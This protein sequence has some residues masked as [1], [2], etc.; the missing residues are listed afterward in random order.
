MYGLTGFR[1]GSIGVPCGPHARGPVPRASRAKG[2]RGRGHGSTS[3]GPTVDS[4]GSPAPPPESSIRGPKTFTRTFLFRIGIPKLV[5]RR[6]GRNWNRSRG[7]RR[8]RTPNLPAQGWNWGRTVFRTST[9]HG[10]SYRWHARRWGRHRLGRNAPAQGVGKF[11]WCAVPLPIVDGAWVLL[12]AT[13]L[14][15]WGFIPEPIEMADSPVTFD[16]KI[17]KNSTCFRPRRA[18]G[19]DCAGG[20]INCPSG[21][22]TCRIFQNFHVESD[23]TARH[24][25]GFR[26]TCAN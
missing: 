13:F 11:I 23:G 5:E 6:L 3:V 24:F 19:F 4:Y 25:D 7:R 14:K 21:S 8:D 15:W 26:Y 22:K 1:W 16:M 12:Q 9:I 10:R 17:L 18:V 2:A 20:P